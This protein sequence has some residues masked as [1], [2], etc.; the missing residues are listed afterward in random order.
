MDQR[1]VDALLRADRE[2]YSR[3]VARLRS[4]VSDMWRSTPDLSDEALELWLSRSVPLVAAAA[5]QAGALTA[6]YLVALVEEMTGVEVP[7]VDDLVVSEG[8]RAGVT[9]DDVMSRPMIQARS[10]VGAGVPFRDASRRA[11]V[12]ALQLAVTDSQ[13]ARTH[14]ARRVFAETPGVVGYRRV[15]TGS[16]SCGLCAVASTRRYRKQDLMP[17]HAGCDCGVSPIVGSVDP[18]DVVNEGLL[19]SLDDAVVAE[20]GDDASKDYKDLIVVHDHGETGPTLAVAGHKWMSAAD[21]AART[22]L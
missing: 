3:L 1:R 8:L 11:E 12:R 17:I 6:S 18:G 16:E 7:D 2:T 9:S 5:D 15:L 22:G 10:L 20:F 14:T 4:A 13:L 21:A 19:A